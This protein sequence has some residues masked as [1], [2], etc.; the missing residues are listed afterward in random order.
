MWADA[1]ILFGHTDA[2]WQQNSFGTVSSPESSPNCCHPRIL[3]GVV[4]EPAGCARLWG[5]GEKQCPRVV[6]SLTLE[7]GVL[8]A[9]RTRVASAQPTGAP[10]TLQRGL[11]E[12]WLLSPVYC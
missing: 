9:A 7:D 11:I 4:Y 6:L 3:E 2:G 8:T 1:V 10:E 12:A 5:R